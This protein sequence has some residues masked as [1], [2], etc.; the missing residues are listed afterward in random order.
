VTSRQPL[1]GVLVVDK[2]SGPT[3]FEVVQRVAHALGV[4][5]AGHTGTLDPLAT[6]VLPVCLGEA[7]KLATHLVGH[8]KRYRATV[9]LGIETDTLDAAGRVVAQRAVPS[10]D[11]AEVEAALAPC[12][13][14]FLQ[15]PPAYSAV[16]VDGERAHARARRGE[17]P[18][19]AEREVDVRVLEVALRTPTEIVLDVECAKGTYVRSIAAAIGERLGCGAHLAAL[20]RERVGPFTIERAIPLATIEERPQEARAAVL[21]P[22][23]ALGAIPAVVLTSEGVR[24]VRQGQAVGADGWVRADA[25]PEGA[26]VRCLDEAGALVAVGA[27]RGGAVRALRVLV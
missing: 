8:D 26:V 6:G 23:L 4:K 15:R 20:R 25:A 12:R 9:R 17:A 19:P 24:R 21:A 18:L 3:S 2:P 5:K 14:K 11:D 1:H 27:R 22:A 10:F 13:G 7:T 16:H